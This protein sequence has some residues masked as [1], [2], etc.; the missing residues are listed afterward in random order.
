MKTKT[1]GRN[2]AAISAHFRQAG[3]MADRREQRG[4]ARNIQRELL[5]EAIEH[6]EDQ[7]ELDLREED[8]WDLLDDEDVN[9]RTYF[10]K[11]S[12]PPVVKF[13]QK[14]SRRNR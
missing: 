8:S 3:A 4:G 10:C 13:S 5:Q 6:A 2:A 9:N 14:P 11:D 1:K 12:S 7:R